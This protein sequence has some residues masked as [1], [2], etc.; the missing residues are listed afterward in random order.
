MYLRTYVS[1]YV[2]KYICMYVRSVKAYTLHIE[3]LDHVLLVVIAVRQV[4][5]VLDGA[6]LHIIPAY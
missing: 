2:C 6:T 4:E 1:I 5:P 3:N